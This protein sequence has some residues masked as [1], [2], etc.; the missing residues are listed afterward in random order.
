MVAKKRGTLSTRLETSLPRGVRPGSPGLTDP[1][2]MFP[3]NQSSLLKRSKGEGAGTQLRD[4]VRGRGGLN[5]EKKTE[6]G[7]EHSFH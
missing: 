1:V 3:P 4:E 7:C 5:I 6:D 2:R